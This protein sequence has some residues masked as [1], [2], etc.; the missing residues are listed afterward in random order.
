MV[1]VRKDQ[2]N[3]T[4]KLEVAMHTVQARVQSLTDRVK[5]GRERALT[6]KQE[7]R[8][9][10]AVRELKKAKAVEK[11]LN[12]AR[13]ALDTLERQQDVLAESTLHRELATA[14]KST[15]A[16]VKAKNKGLLAMAESAVDESV[17]IRDDVEDIAAVFENM[18]PAYDTGADEDELLAELESMI[19]DTTALNTVE[20]ESR[21]STKDTGEELKADSFPSVP[22]SSASSGK[23]PRVQE[24]KALLKHDSAATSAL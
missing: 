6:A 12:A 22:G 24:K 5:I 20:P 15:T 14:L 1:G 13:L 7:G 11:Q 18:A 8:N 17:E 10:D 23:S 21:T 4:E 3:E 16:G 2:S 19:T 9:E